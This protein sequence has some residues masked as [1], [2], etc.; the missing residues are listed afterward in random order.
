[1][2]SE[3]ANLGLAHVYANALYDVAASCGQV[4]GVEEELLALQQMLR[5]EPRFRLFLESPTIR[6]AEKHRVIR[7]LLEGFSHPLR[8]FL[9]LLVRR[10]RSQ[11][12][13][14]IVDAYHEL[15]NLAL[16][17]AE[18]ELAGAR[19]LTADELARLAAMLEAKMRRKVVIRQRAR[20]ELLGGFI[21][22]RGD[23]QW[24]T[25]VS[26]R[27]ARLVHHMAEN[28]AAVGVWKEEY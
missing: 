15:A 19:L 17:I 24:D 2:P 25:S 11:Q 5:A 27:L 3:A 16:G 14:M 23:L 10:Q 6:V 1:M 26:R 28:K 8:N 21:L 22:K 13:D 9:C 12:L 20:A 7:I 18:M 4:T